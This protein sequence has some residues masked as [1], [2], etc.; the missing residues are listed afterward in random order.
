[1]PEK[2]RGGAGAGNECAT[3]EGTRGRDETGVGWARV[4][5]KGGVVA[6]ELTAVT[7]T[8][9]STIIFSHPSLS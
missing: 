6:S 9:G 1:M 4:R 2:E 3:G 8:A 7:V 5:G